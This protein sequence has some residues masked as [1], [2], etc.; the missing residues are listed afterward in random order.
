MTKTNTLLLACASLLLTLACAP[1]GKYTPDNNVREDLYGRGVNATDTVTMATLSWKEVFVDPALQDL[2]QKALDN[3]LDLQMAYEHVQQA[4]AALLGAKMAYIPNLSIAPSGSWTY[5]SNSEGSN[6][7]WNYDIPASMS[8]EVDIF[9]RLANRKKLAEAD[10]AQME[11]YRQAVRVSLIA[12]VANSY[13]TLL[14][15]DEQLRTSLAMLDVWQKSVE[16]IHALKKEGFADEVAVSQYE[17]T[18]SSLKSTTAQLAKSIALTENSVSLMCAEPCNTIKRTTLSSQTLPEIMSVGVPIQMLTFRPDV[19]AAQRGVESA[20]YTTKD[21]WLNFF[22]TLSL[23]GT[24]DLTNI[25]SGAIAPITFLGDLGAGLVAPIFSAGKNKSKLRLAESQQREARLVFDQALLNAG[26]EV[27]NAL[28]SGKACIAMSIFYDSQ[29][30]SLIKAR[31]DTELLMNNSQEKTYLDVLA[32]HNAL[33]EAQFNRIA[34]RAEGLQAIV[35]LYAAL[36]GGS[37]Y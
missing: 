32:A 3:N 15:L 37:E 13:Y 23:N 4:N 35:S 27:N 12:S 24:A 6:S 36:G 10:V 14:M 18:F 8:W 33:I 1:L 19:R 25:L 30:A 16:A 2:I 31:D 7:F 28:V 11:D 5:M 20:F 29:V 17:A 26:M 9:G 21:A 34:N 22:P